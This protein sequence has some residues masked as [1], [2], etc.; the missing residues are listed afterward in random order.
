VE[1][2]GNHLNVA[3][4]I[5]EEVKKGS[6]HIWRG[7]TNKFNNAEETLYT[8]YLDVVCKDARAVNLHRNRSGPL[9]PGP[10]PCSRSMSACPVASSELSGRSC[11]AA[12]SKISSQ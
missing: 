6:R 11:V 8:V 12:T 3:E 7:I 9:L 1:R 5:E 2:H 4:M 10:G